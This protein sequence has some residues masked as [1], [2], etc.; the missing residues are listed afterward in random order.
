MP[1][2][3]SYLLPVIVFCSLLASS[4]AH[5]HEVRP[6][7]LEITERQTGEYDVYWKVPRSAGM[8]LDIRPVFPKHFEAVAAVTQQIV[9]DAF[10]EQWVTRSD[11]SLAGQTIHIAGLDKTMTDVLVRIAFLDGGMT[12]VRLTATS[13]SYMIPA[14]PSMWS[15]A[16]T[17]L[18]LGVEHILFGI[19]HLLFVLALL[20]IVDGSWKLIQTITAFTIAHSVTLALATIGW[21]HVPGPPV[22]AI[23]A[24]SIVFVAVETLKKQQG[25]VGLTQ[26]QPWIV[27]FS[28]G[29]L[30]G[31]GFAGALSE[32]GLPPGDIPMALLTFNIGVEV[33]QLT[34]VMAF[35][36]AWQLLKLVPLRWPGWSAKLL[37]YGIGSIA[38]F[39]VID[40]IAAF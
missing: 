16:W 14:I 32:V 15:V 17:Y 21:V 6:G 25:I 12:T 18:V 20:L 7:Y 11:K 30:H 34:F 31:F 19:D 40:R 27:A 39:W 1:G 37:P 10:V 3:D 5:A 26:R 24:L 22:E 13:S 23:I 35:L 28:F 38:A 9:G 4:A 33:G 36:L 8:K 29:L 2:Y